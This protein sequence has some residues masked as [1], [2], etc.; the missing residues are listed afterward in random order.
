MISKTLNNV[1]TYRRSLQERNES[2]ILRALARDEGVAG[3]LV[4]MRWPSCCVHTKGSASRT[5]I[6]KVAGTY[7]R[8]PRE[9]DER[10]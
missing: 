6:L 8:I 5:K 7:G 10:G 9:R 2:N 4:R 3:I 1:S